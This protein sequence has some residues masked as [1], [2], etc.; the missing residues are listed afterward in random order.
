MLPTFINDRQT[1]VCQASI[2]WYYALL[3][4]V[5]VKALS[6]N[7]QRVSQFL[8]RVFFLDNFLIFLHFVLL[9]SD[10]WDFFLNF[11][12][13][14]FRGR[15]NA[16]LSA[17]ICKGTGKADTIPAPAAL[18]SGEFPMASCQAAMS[19]VCL[20]T[21]WLLALCWRAQTIRGSSLPVDHQEICMP[22][23]ENS[24]GLTIM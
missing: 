18:A 3:H 22:T 16:Y 11:F 24:L 12:F 4:S 23:G 14:F 10:R 19:T 2:I 9:P 20:H 6:A 17:C 13:S 21:K 8:S 7:K 5:S 1:T 15:C